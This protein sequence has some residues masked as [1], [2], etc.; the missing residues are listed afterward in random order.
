MSTIVQVQ[1]DGA[2]KL[3]HEVNGFRPGQLLQVT[4][5][6][7]GLLLQPI[8]T[9][10]AAG[11]RAVA[12]CATPEDVARVDAIVESHCEQIDTQSWR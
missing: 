2:V 3:P 8:T 10:T 1:P 9:P 4:P 5:T 7:N 12:G 11:W 6:N